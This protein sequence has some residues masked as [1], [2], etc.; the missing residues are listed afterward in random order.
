MMARRIESSFGTAVRY[1]DDGLARA[2]TITRTVTGASTEICVSIVAPLA[3]RKA[4]LTA[5]AWLI[6]FPLK[7]P[8]GTSR[9]GTTRGA[10]CETESATSL[11]AARAG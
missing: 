6:G 11:I 2:L 5:A 10:T 3:S 7:S 4:T 9:A 1:G 8:E